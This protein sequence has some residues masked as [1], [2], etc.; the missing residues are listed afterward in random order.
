MS[1]ER[2][3]QVAA[4]LWREEW[5]REMGE[6]PPYPWDSE[7]YEDGLSGAV[8]EGYRGQARAALAAM[9]AEPTLEDQS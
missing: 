4:A 2:I 3:E 5:L 9:D 7:E 8:F 6:E 1:D